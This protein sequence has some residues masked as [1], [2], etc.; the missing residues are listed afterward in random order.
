MLLGE[1]LENADLPDLA[2]MYTFAYQLLDGLPSSYAPG[3][4]GLMIK[5]ENFPNNSFLDRLNIDD[6]YDL[7]GLYQGV[8]LPQKINKNPRVDTIYL[9][10]GPLIRYAR[11]H[12]RDLKN[13]VECVLLQE[14][15][16]HFGFKD[17]AENL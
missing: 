10:R 7:L 8:P 4:R 13:L 16:H 12:N 9:F 17:L 2:D 5:V 14:I 11:D 15:S 3:L 6:K 1:R